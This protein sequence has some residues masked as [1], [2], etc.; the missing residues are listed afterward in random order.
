MYGFMKKHFLF[1]TILCALSSMEAMS[2]QRTKTTQTDDNGTQTVIEEEDTEDLWFGP[3]FYYGIWFDDEDDY[4]EWRGH[5]RDYPSN[6]RYYHSDHPIHY[7][8]QDQNPQGNG[9][10]GGGRRR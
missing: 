7:D 6:H 10:Q 9:H 5:H 4:W 8:H 3:G 1:L 2:A